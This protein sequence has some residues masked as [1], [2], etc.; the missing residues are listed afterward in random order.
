MESGALPLWVFHDQAL[1]ERELEKIFG[2]TW[3]FLAHETEIPNPGD[4]V[5]R[6]IGND[7]FIVVRGQDNVVRVLFDSCRH[8]GARLCLADKGNA[9][10][11]FCP[12]HGW[13]YRTTGELS[14]VPNIHT[15]YKAL[16]LK[17]WGLLPAPRSETYRGLIFASLDP[18]IRSARGASWRLS[19]VSRSPSCVVAGRH[20]GGRRTASLAHRS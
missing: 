19:L 10:S 6:A 18:D 3:I 13:T 14:G 1:Y 7:P 17:Q 15:A 11:F 8:R 4:Y 2:R 16:D 12:Y 20:G 5:A 9:K